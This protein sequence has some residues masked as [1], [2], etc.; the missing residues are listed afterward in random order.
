MKIIE[1]L[2]EST[3]QFDPLLIKFW[4]KHQDKLPEY[5]RTGETGCVEASND[6]A[7]EIGG[8]AYVVPIGRFSGSKKVGG[9]LY[10][11]TPQTDLESFTQKE[12]LAM[13]KQGLDPSKEQDRVTFI[14]NNKLEDEFKWIPHSWVEV[15][16]KILDPSGFYIDGKSGQ[17]DRLVNNKSN[18]SQ[19]YT[20]F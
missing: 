14:T 15:R 3:S 18:L 20:Y 12:I 11:D 1:L 13:K 4:N 17:F 2:A 16:G 7:D 8:F 19:R 6:L 5:F 10:T 9:W